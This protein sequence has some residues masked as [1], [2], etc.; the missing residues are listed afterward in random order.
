MNG[1]LLSSVVL[2][3]V[4]MGMMEGPAPDAPPRRNAVAAT[5]EVASKEW[6]RRIAAL[7]ARGDLRVLSARE[8]TMLAGRTHTRYAQLYKGVPVW[9]GE[10]VRQEDTAGTLTVF[11]NLYEGIDIEPRPTLSEAAARRTLEAVHEGGRLF[12]AEVDLVVLPLGAETGAITF[13]LAWRGQILTGTDARAVFVDAHSG[14]VRLD[15]TDRDTQTAVGKGTGVLGDPK[16]MS[17]T[18]T[19]A[20]FQAQDALRPPILQTLDMK[21]DPLRIESILIPA[22]PNSIRSTDYAADSD[23]DWTDGGVVDAHVYTGYT[24]DYYFKRFGRRGLNDANT[25]VRSFVNLVKREDLARN[26]ALY[27]DDILDYYVNAFYLHP[28]VM[29][30]GVGLPTNLTLG[31]Q[32]WNNFAGALDVVGHELTHGVTAFTS[33]LIYQGES[34]ALN[35]AFS[36]IMGTSIEFY[37]QPPGNGSMQAD[38]LEGEDIAT[39][40]SF[41]LNGIRSMQ[42]PTAYGDPDHYSVRYTG[43]QDNG[44]VHINSGIANNAYYLAIEGGTHRLGARVIGVGAANRE[45]IEKVFYRAFT[46]FLVPSSNFAAARAA[47]IRAASELYPSNPAVAAALAQAWT[48][49]GVN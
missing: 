27:G 23:N 42:N 25:P 17:V 3:F 31:G 10:L 2:A 13:V 7:S 32:R 6:D 15:Y 19:G 33:R 35:E 41:P 9:G 16:K 20:T 48:A 40:A 43:T 45:Q 14:A 21:G 38:Y 11:G 4:G 49:V 22:F 24:Y 44:G 39:A 37:F 28:G 29:V 26:L 47:T 8:D 18:G 34:G 46:A 12:P 36:D 5:S 30:Y 1:K